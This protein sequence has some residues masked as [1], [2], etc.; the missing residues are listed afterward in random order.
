MVYISHMRVLL[1]ISLVAALTGVEQ[2]VSPQETAATV[3]AARQL[4]STKAWAELDHT[5]ATLSP[6]DPAWEKL[7][8]IIYQGGVTRNDLPW[9]LD[10]LSRVAA[11]TS[12]GSIKASALIAVGRA[13]RRQ[14]DEGS[15]TRSLEQAKTAAPGT[16]YAEEAEGL[17][18]DIQHL[19]VGRPAPPISAKAR[20]GRNISLAALRGKAV[21]LVFWGTT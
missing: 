8:A 3:A 11:L 4:V 6:D 13:Y 1:A 7:P 17:L 16:S 2:A 10:R 12:N 21:V 18:Y 9:V 20:N 14:G 15:A 5:L 19:S